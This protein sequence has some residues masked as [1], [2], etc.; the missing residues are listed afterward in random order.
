MS[1]PDYRIRFPSAKIDFDEDVHGGSPDGQD[2]ND[3]PEPGQARYDWMRMV[4]IGLLANQ[5]SEEE[6]MNY[7]I[8]T[9]WMNLNDEFFKYFNGEEFAELANAIRI[10]ETSLKD[11][12]ELVDETVGKVTEAASFTGVAQSTITEIDVPDS[13]L[14]AASYDNNHPVL[15]KND[16]LVDPRLTTFNLDRDKVLLLDNDAGSV[17]LRRN[18]RYTI[19]IQRLDT[20]VPETIIVS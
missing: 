7:K 19:L 12:S 15:Y 9:L 1:I 6:P 2:V 11:W 3:F 18:D 8:G 17:D 13:A 10:G 5:S 16:L 4:V 14:V 20:V